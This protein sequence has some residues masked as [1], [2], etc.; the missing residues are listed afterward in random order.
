MRKSQSSATSTDAN[1]MHSHHPLLLVNIKLIRV[2]QI[3]V[4]TACEHTTLTRVGQMKLKSCLWTQSLF[5]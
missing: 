4:R 2:G 1:E 5:G 3:K